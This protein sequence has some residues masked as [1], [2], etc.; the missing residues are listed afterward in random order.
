METKLFVGISDIEVK[1]DSTGSGNTIIGYGSTWGNSDLVGDVVAPNAFT[2]S[3]SSGKK[4]KML[5][6]HDWREP[7]GVW[8]SIT[9]DEKGLRVEGKLSNTAK[10]N[11][12]KNLLRDGAIDGLSVSFM[13][14]DYEYKGD[15]RIIKEAEL[16]EISVVSRPCNEQALISE[17]KSVEDMTEREFEKKLRDAVGLSKKQAMS[18]MSAGFKTM[19]GLRDADEIDESNENEVETEH[20]QE[21]VIENDEEAIKAESELKNELLKL[22]NKFQV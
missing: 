2:K 4:I 11:E 22:L 3:L 7:I 9:E 6:M 8:T 5:W 1:S 13:T 18:L 10:S 12:I 20:K 15:N 14:K 21:P 17:V 16:L 19:K